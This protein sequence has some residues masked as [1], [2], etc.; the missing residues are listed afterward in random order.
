[1]Q[2]LAKLEAKEQ[3]RAQRLAAE[4]AFQSADERLRTVKSELDSLV[5]TYRSLPDQI[6]VMQAR[7]SLALRSL[8]DAKSKLEAVAA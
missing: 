7:F 8:N 1:M 3:A 2:R 5:A 6:T 4:K